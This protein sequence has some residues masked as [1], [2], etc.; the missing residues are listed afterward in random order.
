[1]T[2]MLC[3]MQHVLSSGHRIHARLRAKH[4]PTCAHTKQ[5]CADEQQRYAAS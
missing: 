1:M 4:E 5:Q 2:A 3:M